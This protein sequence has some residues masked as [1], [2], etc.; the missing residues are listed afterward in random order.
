[1]Q[2]RFQKS[3]L[4]AGMFSGVISVSGCNYDLAEEALSEN[5][6]PVTQRDV[7][8]MSVEGELLGF[9][10]LSNDVDPKGETLFITNAAATVGSVSIEDNRINYFAPAGYEGEVSVLYTVS[11]GFWERTEFLVIDV[12]GNGSGSEYSGGSSSAGSGGLNRAPVA[13]DDRVE[14]AS[15]LGATT[16]SVLANDYDEDGDRIH[17]I[18]VVVASGEGTAS[19]FDDVVIYIPPK[20]FEGEVSLQYIISDGVVDSVGEAIVNVVGG[21][22][23][24]VTQNDTAEMV[25]GGVLSGVN[26]LANDSDPEKSPLKLVDAS[27]GVGNVEFTELGAITFTPNDGFEGVALVTYTVSDGEEE[28]EGELLVTVISGNIAPVVVDDQATIV[29]GQILR[30]FPVLDNDI[31]PN[32][33][34]LSVV[35]V[36]P[37]VGSGAS[38]VIEADN[39]ITYTSPPGIYSDIRINYT[40]SDGQV[41]VDGVLTVT[42]LREE[43]SDEEEVVE[44]AEPPRSGSGDY[45]MSLQLES[46]DTFDSY[47][48]AY[49]KDADAD[50]TFEVVDSNSEFVNLEVK[51]PGKYKVKVAPYYGDLVGVF[52]NEIDYT[53]EG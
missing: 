16:V 13:E 37:V 26:V 53:V 51:A 2:I 27:S 29:F 31:D 11:D 18:D 52:S 5:P 20:G 3:F 44:T 30:N 50:Y 7:A 35:R 15:G 17:L 10:V 6:A 14:M 12:G 8:S 4:L 1:M 24:P 22:K 46:N 41:E 28:A 33:D 48:V 43:P 9:D 40:V 42:V 47:L 19:V 32:G 34:T 21:N 36:R 23:P 39:T 25:Q 45:D 38:A 49:K